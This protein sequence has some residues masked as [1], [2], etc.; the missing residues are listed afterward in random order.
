MWPMS[1]L[2][3]GLKNEKNNLSFFQNC[4]QTADIFSKII[5]TTQLLQ[6][7]N[8]FSKMSK[9]QLYFF[10]K[11]NQIADVFQNNFKVLK[12]F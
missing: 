12:G 8:Y 6:I 9:N 7:V 4:K 1:S 2:Q 5:Q 10:S 3:K 11:I